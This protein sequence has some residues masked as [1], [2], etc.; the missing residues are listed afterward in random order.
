L[1]NRFLALD[2]ELARWEKARVAVL[3]V[4]YDATTSY[5][6]GSRFGPR[7]LIDASRYLEEFDPELGVEPCSVGIY[8]CPEV[9]PVVGDPKAMLDRVES[10]VSYLVQDGKFVALVGGE[11][12]LTL[13][14]VRAHSSAYGSLSVLQLDAHL[15][16]RDTYQDSAFSHACAMRRVWEVARVV[17]VGVR[18]CSEGELTWL[19]EQKIRCFWA[20]ELKD[21]VEWMDEVCDSLGD[22]VY[23]TV[24]L[25]VFDPA[26]MPSVGTPE[27]GGLDWDTVTELLRKVARRTHVVGF[28]LV[29]L[30]PIPGNRAPDVLAAKLLYKMV[31]YIFF[32]NPT[33]RVIYGEEE[34]F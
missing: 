27:P 5:Q 24:D 23:I 26:V 22:R 15:D 14:A 29:E 19:R 21:K 11:H 32:P 12:T 2:E 20:R 17:P 7:A 28:D 16:L 34:A 31:G 10:L 4:P 3:P 1:P 18:S 8:T 25:D 30:A 13:A 33:R 9:E 6:P